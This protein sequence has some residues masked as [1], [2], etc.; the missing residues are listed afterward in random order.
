MSAYN[1]AEICELVGLFIVCKFQ[2]L[3]EINNFGLYRDDGS[4]I[5]KNTSGP[6]SETLIAS[7]IWGIWFNIDYWI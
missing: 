3:A 2:Q 4:A 5:A 1:G 7:T 6:L